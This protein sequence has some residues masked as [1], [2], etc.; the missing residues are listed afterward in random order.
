MRIAYLTQCYPPAV[1]GAAIFARQ[2]AEGM[3][4][5]GHQV[6]VIAPG[7]DGIPRV[8][9]QGNL[10]LISLR[11]FHNPL[12]ARQRFVPGPRRRIPHALTEFKPDII[13]S[14]DFF[15]VGM[16][17]IHFARRAGVPTI[18]T[19]HQLRWFV[20]NH[21]PDHRLLRHFTEEVLWGYG[22]WLL[23]QCTVLVA[24]TRTVAEVVRKR[25]TLPARVISNGVDLQT[26]RP[27]LSSAEK[28]ASRTRLN[29]PPGIPI[30][31]HVGQLHRAKRVDRALEAAAQAM[32]DTKAHLLV[33]GD[34]PLKAALMNLCQ[35]LGIED[36]AHFPGYITV[37]MGLPEVYRAADIFVTAS[38]IETQGI[39]LLE[40][41]ASGLPIAAVD[42]T[43]IG[44]IVHNGVNGYLTGSGEA[45]AMSDAI[46]RILTEAK[47]A[48]A[49]SVAS[50]R[51]AENH[52]HFE[53]VN[54][55]ERMYNVLAGRE[56]VMDQ[57]KISRRDRLYN[58]L[59]A[60]VQR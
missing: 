52:A 2:L 34:G 49:M 35:T 6:M 25:T 56:P 9:Q 39:V 44:E 53:T 42:A 23:R 31:L 11:S 47:I 8:A 45:G 24:P 36:R 1:S 60:I 15:Q 58:W 50:R 55:Y 19:L 13:H 40:A 22:C 30:I 59:A 28:A 7:G 48:G 12:R 18:T 26:F 10:T 20:S 14:H 17:G 21:L 3:A 46:R 37:E 33:V 16:A 41:A 57:P 32:Q 27:P 43:C 5:L 38:E 51:L 29:L 54:Q 4:Q